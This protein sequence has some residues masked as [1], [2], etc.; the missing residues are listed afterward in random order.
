MS[1]IAMRNRVAATSLALVGALGLT[2]CNSDTTVTETT[3]PTS[4]STSE[5]SSSTSESPST[6]ST[7]ESSSSTSSTSSTSE[8]PSTSSTSESSSASTGAESTEE[9]P[10]G[11][12]LKFGSPATIN[13]SGKVFK[14]TVKE[15][16][17][18]PESIYSQKRL[19]KANGTVYYINF[20]VS[21]VKSDG[22]FYASSVN[23]LWMY[24]S[25]DQGQKAK[26]MY[27]STDECKSSYDKLE[28]GQTG[29]GCYIYQIDGPTSKTVTYAN[30]NHRLTWE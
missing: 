17:V 28:I 29:S 1:S 26:R 22:T 27:G 12:T 23:G 18:A 4:S 2:A 16:K 7:S 3:T 24:P 30:S 19:D 21:P 25:F 15:L 14:L 5:S 6:S 9:T 8:S 20:D 11:T 10:K 13:E